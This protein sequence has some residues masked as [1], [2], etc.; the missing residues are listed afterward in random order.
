MFP[1]AYQPEFPHL[2]HVVHPY[3][4]M[5]NVFHQRLHFLRDNIVGYG[6]SSSR[7]PESRRQYFSTDLSPYMPSDSLYYALNENRLFNEM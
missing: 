6:S 5:D 2:P 7:L 1:E 3:D 4:F